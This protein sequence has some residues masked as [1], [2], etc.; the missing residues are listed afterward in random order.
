MMSRPIVSGM[1]VWRAI[2]PDRL[3]VLTIS[4]TG[5]LQFRS[6][7]IVP[8][9]STQATQPDWTSHHVQTQ[10]HIEWNAPA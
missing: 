2:A 9:D 4:P 3:I 7:S 6:I 8:A 1:I 5:D 10:K